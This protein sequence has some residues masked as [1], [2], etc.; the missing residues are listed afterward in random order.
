M[1]RQDKAELSQLEDALKSSEALRRKESKTLHPLAKNL[2]PAGEKQETSKGDVYVNEGEKESGSEPISV[3]EQDLQIRPLL[4][5]LRNHLGSMRNNTSS[6][7]PVAH[8][9]S[10]AQHALD[11][12]TYRTLDMQQYH[13]LYGLET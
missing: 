2:R 4:S 6:M 12:F 11:I 13:L 5:Q 3:L 1:L 7:R 8:A 9:L 10:D